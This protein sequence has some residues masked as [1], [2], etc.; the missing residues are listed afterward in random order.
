MHADSRLGHSRRREGIV[1]PVL[2]ALLLH[3][4]IGGV[5]AFL[6]MVPAT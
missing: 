3:G 4:F 6:V 1:L 5:F 2:M